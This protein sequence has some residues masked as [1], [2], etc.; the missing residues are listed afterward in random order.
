MI[1]AAVGTRRLLL[2]TVALVGVLGSVALPLTPAG[3]WLEPSSLSIGYAIAALGVAVVTGWAG[4]VFLAPLAI[5][6]L[7]AYAT[8]W[9]AGDQGQP[10][11][12]AVTYALALALIAG[13]LLGAL[14]ATRRNNAIVA[15]VSYGAA[16]VLDAAV[17]RSH[18]IGGVRRLTPPVSA[19]VRMGGYE[20]DADVV[21]Y[22]AILVVLGICLLALLVLQDSR[23][24]RMLRA[25][26]VRAGG[27]EVRGVDVAATRFA[28]HLIA[29]LLF[30][31][32]GC[33]LAADTG[34]VA[35]GSFSP[36]QSLLL[37]GLVLIG[38]GRV[39]AA[40]AAGVVA[41]AVPD[42][43]S[44]YHPIRGYVPEDLDLAVGGLLLLGVVGAEL[45][46][47]SAARAWLERRVPRWRRRGSR[48]PG[49][50]GLAVI[51]RRL[52]R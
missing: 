48:D 23:L 34:R 13:A 51:P 52:R 1:V 22:Y 49:A 45:L 7:A 4:E 39:L 35:P 36:L 37:V 10:M 50:S 32:A 25:A 31:I 40:L 47:G 29:A 42:L 27:A 33:C 28:A 18:A 20:V 46:R 24:A 17:F 5:T 3:D 30:G 6:G 21:L 9:F 19:P 41:G 14:C 12:I 8:A 26:R 16:A 38:S 11:V 2:L 43:M 15:I 44:R